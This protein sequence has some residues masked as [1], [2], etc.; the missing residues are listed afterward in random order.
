[1][2]GEVQSGGNIKWFTRVIGNNGRDTT[3]NIPTQ[4]MDHNKC[5]TPCTAKRPAYL[6]RCAGAGLTRMKTYGSNVRGVLL[7]W[8]S[9]V[10]L[11]TTD[12]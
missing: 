12:W 6:P 5:S 3:L 10:K 4:R 9:S 8:N 11:L 1:M 2:R 7:G